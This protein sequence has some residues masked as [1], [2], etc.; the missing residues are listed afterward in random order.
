MRNLILTAALA[1]TA[2]TLAACSQEADE[3]VVENE[4]MG[5]AVDDMAAEND[6]VA[7]LDAS[8]AT[9]GE[10]AA[11]DGVSPELATAIV[12]GQPYA[13]IIDLN[14]VLMRMVSEEEAAA[15]RERVFVPVNLN[16]TT[17][18]ELALIPGIDDRMIHEFEEYVPYE[19]MAEFDRE[20]GK[21]IEAD[22]IARYRQ[23]VTLNAE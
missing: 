17:S 2:F 9:E 12:G 18:E 10:L 15:I 11:I 19:D 6:S 1:G 21:Y 14:T 5:E 3:P 7:V 13:N 4:T 8:T 23:Y 22:E 20:M 16:N